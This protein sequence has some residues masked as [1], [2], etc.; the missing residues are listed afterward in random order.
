VINVRLITFAKYK[1]GSTFGKELLGGV[2]ITICT[3][4]HYI[5]MLLAMSFNVYIF[6]CVIVGS[7]IGHMIDHRLRKRGNVKDTDLPS[8]SDAKE[9]EEMESEVA[10]TCHP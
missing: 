8:S 9:V 1:D 3:G 2:A 5:L 7:G 10:G 4:L 6:V